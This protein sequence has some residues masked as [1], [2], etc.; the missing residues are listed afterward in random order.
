MLSAVRKASSR[1]SRTRLSAGRPAGGSSTASYTT[2]RMLP[3]R[4]TPMAPPSSYDT[5]SIEAA[6]PARSGGALS[7][8]VLEAAVMA[9]P[10]PM[11]STNRTNIGMNAGASYSSMQPAMPRPDRNRL[12]V[13]ILRLPM[14]GSQRPAKGP[15]MNEATGNG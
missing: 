3:M 6:M 1:L 13:S 7:I 11:P 2:D 14:R 4:V 9:A 15:E 10:S 5:S 12:A 8:M